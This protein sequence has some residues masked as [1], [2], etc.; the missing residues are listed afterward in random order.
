MDTDGKAG[1]ALVKVLGPF[2]LGLDD[3]LAGAVDETVLG[4]EVGT[5]AD[6]EQAVARVPDAVE[7]DR[8]VGDGRAVEEGC[9][10]AT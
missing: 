9:A 1:E 3:Q 7:I 6:V 2:Q 8:R 5:G 10:W 4:A